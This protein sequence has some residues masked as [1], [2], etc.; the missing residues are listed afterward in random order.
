MHWEDTQESCSAPLPHEMLLP[1]VIDTQSLSKKHQA[2]NTS[3]VRKIGSR[4]N[5]VAL[6]CPKILLTQ[7]RFRA[8]RTRQK[9]DVIRYLEKKK[10]KTHFHFLE[11]FAAIVRAR[12]HVIEPVL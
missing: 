3:R 12:I 8:L 10:S 1:L 5:S 7:N 9:K 2:R 4:K 11:V 6:T